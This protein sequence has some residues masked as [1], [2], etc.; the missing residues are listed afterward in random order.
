MA[1]LQVNKNPSQREL[2]WFGVVTFAFFAL[3]GVIIW[4]NTRSVEALQWIVGVAAGLT[5]IYY[6]VPPLRRSF[7]LA[8]MYSIHPVG[9]VLSHVILGVVYFGLFTA[10]GLIMRLVGYD[11]M[12]RRFDREAATYWVKRP[13][14]AP[15]ARYFRQF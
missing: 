8:W 4:V 6:A 1:I 12:A 5:V 14:P 11:P 10:V 13:P 7:Y 3:A 9:W 2:R 15:H